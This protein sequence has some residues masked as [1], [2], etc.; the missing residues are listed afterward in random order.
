L[1]AQGQAEGPGTKLWKSEDGFGFRDL[2]DAINPLQHLPV[3]GTI[4][5]AMTGDTIG[6]APRLI[7]GT[8]F[9]G[10]VGFVTSLFN[11]LV[12]TDTGKDVGAHVMALLDDSKDKSA[13][14]V[15]PTGN[16][17][18]PRMGHADEQLA[19]VPA[20]LPSAQAIQASR[21]VAVRPIVN[22]PTS[23]HRDE[24]LHPAP[25]WLPS[26]SAAPQP[27]SAEPAPSVAAAPKTGSNVPPSQ[28]LSGFPLA[29]AMGKPS[30]S[31]QGMPPQGMPPGL[32]P[33]IPPSA[34][35]A[36][37]ARNPS[38]GQPQ[39]GAPTVSAPQGTVAAYSAGVPGAGIKGMPQPLPSAPPGWNGAGTNA[40]ATSAIQ[41]QQLPVATAPEQ[42]PGAM[43]QALDKY[44]Q[45]I[46]ARKQQGQ[47]VSVLN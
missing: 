11:T 22:F 36:T 44:E 30:G 17:P 2:I 40:A 21:Q 3:V 23:M 31:P 43:Q 10:P 19:L 37:L 15:K 7:G 6:A 34:I 8:L 13:L 1:P 24:Q 33:G 46:K 5:R 27:F 41:T 32:P 28:N 26:Q 45:M 29:M 9:G 20:E 42:V 16:I 47:Q 12:E 4:Y 39:A 14:A 18:S 25:A 38:F 35:A